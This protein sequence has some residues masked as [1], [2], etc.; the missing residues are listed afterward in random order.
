MTEYI[1]KIGNTHIDKC[2]SSNL[3]TKRYPA[4]LMCWHSGCKQQKSCDRM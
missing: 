3:F 4:L 2:V 1:W